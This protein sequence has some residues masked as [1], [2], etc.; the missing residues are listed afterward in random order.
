MKTSVKKIDANKREL[1][2]EVTGEIVKNKF[3]EVYAH[4]TNE[5][6]VAGFRPGKVPRNILEKQH[7]ALANERVLNEL[8]PVLCD[9]ALKNE[10]IDAVQI[11][12][13]KDV[14]LRSDFLSFK[15]TLEVKPQIQLKD[16]KGMKLEYK[17]IVVTDEELNKAKDQIK[18]AKKA[19]N[20]DDNLARSLG[21]VNA[22]ELEDFLRHNIYVQ[23]DTQ[24]HNNLEA[25]IVES[26]LKDVQFELP[27]SMVERQLKDLAYHTKVDLS[28]RGV[29]KEQ[30]EAE[31]ENI[32]KRLEPEAQKQV[33]IYLILEEI[34]KRENIPVDNS[35]PRKVMEFLLSQANWVEKA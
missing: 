1:A 21:Y 9:D 6:K 5:V 8:L 4:M 32:Q 26:L 29:T 3:D 2:V 22:Q 27:K 20:I 28:M 23:K 10:K 30:I 18:E 13:I 17:K 34:A 14:E 7:S 31:D 16:Y 24:Q 33:R 12:Q 15:A 19:Q 25:K 35:M 11:S